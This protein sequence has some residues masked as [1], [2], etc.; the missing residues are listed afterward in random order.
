MSTRPKK[1]LSASQRARIVRDAKRVERERIRTRLITLLRTL[2]TTRG[3]DY[4]AGWNA[5]LAH[6]EASVKG[7]K[8]LV[9]PP[10]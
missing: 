4:G 8:V 5:A 2:R 9:I 1:D 6:L 10:W 7:H 3:D